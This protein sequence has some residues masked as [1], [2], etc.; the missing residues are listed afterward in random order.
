[1]T[2]LIIR[3]RAEA[4]SRWP[5]FGQGIIMK[6]NRLIIKVLIVDVNTVH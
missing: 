2:I 1:M 3:I 4:Q 6:K 5:G